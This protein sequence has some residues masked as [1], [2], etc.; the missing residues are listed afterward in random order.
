MRVI[1]KKML[2][3]FGEKH[4]DA[5][6]A[7]LR[8]YKAVEDAEW[9]NFSETR[10]AFPHADQVR[11][12]SGRPVT[13]FNIGGNKYRLISAI[14]YNRQVVF[15]LRMYTHKEYDVNAWKREL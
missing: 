15:V 7:L 13:V 10:A 12:A 8:W 1:S 9:T 11:V 5:R 4:P 14:H 2:Q 3:R 6:G